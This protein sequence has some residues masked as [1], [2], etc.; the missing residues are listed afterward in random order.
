MV[1]AGGYPGREITT[2]DPK[3]KLSPEKAARLRAEYLKSMQ[4]GWLIQEELER[5]SG[6][7]SFRLRNMQ[8]NDQGTKS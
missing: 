8:K 3:K 7:V 4:T 2:N 1:P 6:I 5:T